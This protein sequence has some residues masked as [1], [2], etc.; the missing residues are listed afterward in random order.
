MGASGTMIGLIFGIYPLVV[1]VVAPVIGVLV[2]N[3]F[4]VCDY[5]INVCVCMR[6]VYI[7][8]IFITYINYRKVIPTINNNYYST[9][10]CWI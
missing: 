4:N 8:L 5:Y 10:M 6:S 7:I 3:C 2:S 9:S 1:F